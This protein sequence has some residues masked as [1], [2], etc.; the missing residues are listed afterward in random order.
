MIDMVDKGLKRLNRRR[1][2]I[3]VIVLLAILLISFPI[4]MYFKVTTESRLALREAKNVK[5]TLNMLDVQYY[6]K[7]KSVYTA[8]RPNGLTDGVYEAVCENL[9]HDCDLAITAYDRSSRTVLGFVYTYGHH[10]VVYRYDAEK[11]DTW[12][13]SYIIDIF[14]YDGE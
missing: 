3:T 7:D 9:E 2:I 8:N 5:L 6:A 12:K 1:V 10:Q 14:N 13:V 11:G 4:F